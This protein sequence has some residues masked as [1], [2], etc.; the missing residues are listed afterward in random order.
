M[1]EF[2]KQVWKKRSNVSNKINKFSNPDHYRIMIVRFYLSYYIKITL[3]SHFLVQHYICMLCWTIIGKTI[4]QVGKN[5][6]M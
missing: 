6:K 3:K 5:D 1:I 2:I 4:K